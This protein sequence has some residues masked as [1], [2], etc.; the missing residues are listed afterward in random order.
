MS[1]NSSV[2]EKDVDTLLLNVSLENGVETRFIF[3]TIEAI[4]G[5]FLGV[6]V[7]MGKSALIDFRLCA[8]CLFSFSRWY[9]RSQA[10]YVFV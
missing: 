7:E 1:L 8:R 6:L 10:S 9:N 5:T 4:C 2:K 3:S